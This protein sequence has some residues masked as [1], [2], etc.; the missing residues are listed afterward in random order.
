MST[1]DQILDDAPQGFDRRRF[2]KAGAASA[3]AAAVLAACGGSSDD[4]GSAVATT[5][6]EP[7]ATDK[8]EVVLRTATSLALA[9]A[10][11]YERAI[12]SG[13]LSEGGKVVAELFL[14]H[15]QNHAKVFQNET[16]KAG[17]KPVSGP[18]SAVTQAISGRLAFAS[19]ADAM[20][21]AY[22]LEQTAVATYVAAAGTLQTTEL[23]EVVLGAAGVDGRH[24]A[25][26]GPL[27]GK[28]QV[29]ASGFAPTTGGVA[30]GT[31]L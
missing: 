14:K 8:D 2:L 19:E 5:T 11:V 21:L 9:I 30:P 25:V 31:G 4:A 29:A 10:G 24:L 17:G 20:N 7:R 3:F 15:H 6:T 26:I 12:A 28:P 13:V 22:E 27:V 18:N 23:N 1:M 16:L